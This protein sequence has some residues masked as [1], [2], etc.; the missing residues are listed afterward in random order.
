MSRMVSVEAIEKGFSVGE[1]ATLSL[2][3]AFVDGGADLC[4]ILVRSLDTGP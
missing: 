3:R 2:R 1:F 4:A